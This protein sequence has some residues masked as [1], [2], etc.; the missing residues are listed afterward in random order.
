MRKKVLNS[1]CHTVKV[2]TCYLLLL[3][4]FLK[5]S[6]LN[7]KVVIVFSEKYKAQGC[8]EIT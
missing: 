2:I 1:V 6:P 8:S 4:I 7:Y 3:L 5:W